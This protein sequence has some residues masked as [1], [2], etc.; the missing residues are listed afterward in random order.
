[1]D[2]KPTTSSGDSPEY[3]VQP[4]HPSSISDAGGGES[5]ATAAAQLSSLD[6]KVQA[7]LSQMSRES[8]CCNGCFPIP[9]ERAAR[10]SWWDPAFDSDILEDQLMVC[11]LLL[12]LIVSL[13]LSLSFT[14]TRLYHKH[15]HS[16]T[17]A[18]SLLLI[19]LSL[20]FLLVV[21]PLPVVC[22]SDIRRGLLRCL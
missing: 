19:M 3:A 10:R 12:V 9:F 15:M 11:S 17:V 2:Q 18:I 21:Y 7:Y 6:P 22:Q 13:T 16:I 5:D 4:D 8:G 1:M 20:I 14:Y